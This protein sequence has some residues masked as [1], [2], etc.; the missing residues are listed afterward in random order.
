MKYLGC[1]ILLAGILIAGCADLATQPVV[2][3]EQDVEITTPDISDTPFLDLPQLVRELQQGKV[4]EADSISWGRLKKKYED[5]D[6]A[7]PG[8]ETDSTGCH[9]PV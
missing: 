6:Q 1:I 7:P 2:K 5:A 8:G 3:S 9:P 4:S